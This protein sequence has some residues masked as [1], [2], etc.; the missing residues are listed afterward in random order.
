MPEAEREAAFTDRQAEIEDL[1]SDLRRKARKAWRQPASFALGLA[2]AAWTYSTGN[3]IGALLAAG[4]LVARGLSGK[5]KEAGAFSY[6]FT[7]HEQYA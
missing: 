4:A 7:A 6:L 3:P 2:G 1:A 5:E